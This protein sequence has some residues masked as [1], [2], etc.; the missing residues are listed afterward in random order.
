MFPRVQATDPW[1]QQF[2]APTMLLVTNLAL[3]LGEPVQFSG[4]SVQA[5]SMG[6]RSPHNT[7]FASIKY[8]SPISG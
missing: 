7:T 3:H 6:L 1:E 8:S 4:R 2:I 5:A